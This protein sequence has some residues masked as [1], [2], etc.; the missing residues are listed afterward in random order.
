MRVA[1]SARAA[2]AS[3]TGAEND[4]HN[5]CRV[6]AG[7]MSFG[8]HSFLAHVRF[9]PDPQNP[10]VQ[11]RASSHRS[12]GVPFAIGSSH[13]PCDSSPASGHEGSVGSGPP[14][15][16]TPNSATRVAEDDAC[17]SGR[18][19]LARVYIRVRVEAGRGRGRGRRVREHVGTRVSRGSLSRTFKKEHDQLVHWGEI[20]QVTAGDLRG[21]GRGVTY[22][23]CREYH[24]RCD[25]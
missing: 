18:K 4:G 25:A 5:P 19:A 7:T 17:V 8:A 20:E 24:E 11:L 21:R 12:K 6:R 1:S 16:P 23:E 10:G 15:V 22:R 2:A 13:P 3:L 9:P 14:E